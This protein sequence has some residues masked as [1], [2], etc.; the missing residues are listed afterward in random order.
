MKA[1]HS[2]GEHG[3]VTPFAEYIS[4]FS[5]GSSITACGLGQIGDPSGG[6][7]R[8]MDY[9]EEA[10]RDFAVY[11]RMNETQLT[12]M[13]RTWRPQGKRYA[14]KR[15]MVQQFI[16]DYRERCGEIPKP[17]EVL[18]AMP[19]VSRKYVAILLQEARG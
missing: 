2:L 19:D 6:M 8:E 9:T 7:P 11:D 10:R 4:A 18:N 14:A 16:A 3:A 12:Q 13:L 15:E 1:S 5:Q 17:R